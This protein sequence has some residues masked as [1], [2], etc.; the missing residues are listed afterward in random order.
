MTACVRALLPRDMNTGA[1]DGI[2]VY[3]HTTNEALFMR[4]FERIHTHTFLC[5]KEGD[6]QVNL[7]D[8]T[9]LP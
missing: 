8:A 7:L 6:Y 3:Y 2:H 1:W 4:A 5:L 9:A